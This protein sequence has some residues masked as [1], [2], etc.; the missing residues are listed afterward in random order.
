MEIRP[1][2]PEFLQKVDVQA[3]AATFKD[4][5]DLLAGGWLVGIDLNAAVLND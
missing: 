4:L 1:I 5:D 3:R 2:V